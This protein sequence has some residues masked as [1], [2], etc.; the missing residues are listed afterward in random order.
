MGNWIVFQPAISAD[1]HLELY[2]PTSIQKIESEAL[3]QGLDIFCQ[4]DHGVPI[5]IMGDGTPEN[6]FLIP[7]RNQAR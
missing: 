5:Q 4:F 1:H 3:K 7:S 2:G 6:P